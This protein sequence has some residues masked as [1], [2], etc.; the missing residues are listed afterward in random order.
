MQLTERSS[1]FPA[2]ETGMPWESPL[3]RIL[4]SITGPVAKGRAV[5]LAVKLDA[6]WTKD[7]ILRMYLDAGYFGHG[8]WGVA[9]AAEGYFGLAPA[10]LSWAQA[11]LLAGRLQAPTAYDPVVHPDRAAARQSHVLDR[12]VAVGDLS[13]AEA[14]AVAGQPWGLLAG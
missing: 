11:S 5:A 8:F 3:N 14:D 10:Q 9:A 12:L 1:P 6:T 7:Q 4:A 13:R 2:S